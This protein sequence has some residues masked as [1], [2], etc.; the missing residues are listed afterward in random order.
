MSFFRLLH[1]ATF[2][3]AL[4]FSANAQTSI[5]DTKMDIST[6]G[7]TVKQII[8]EIEQDFGINF[9]YSDNLLPKT[10]FNEL[11]TR[12][13]LGS[14]LTSMLHP[15]DIDFKVIDNQIVLFESK[16]TD[17][18]CHVSGIMVDSRN[19]EIIINGAIYVSDLGVGAI[20]NNYGFFSIQMPEGVHRMKFHS[21]GYKMQD[22]VIEINGDCELAIRLDPVSYQ[23]REIT[24][25][26]A[27]DNF[28][29]SAMSNI[30]KLNIERLKEL[31]NV[32]GEHDALRNLDVMPGFQM[33]E[34]STSN[35][36]VRGGTGDQTTFLMDEANIYSASHLGG[37]SSIFNPDVVN[38]INIYKNEL[39]TSESG[40]LSSVIDVRLRD[41]DM[42]HWHASGTIGLLTARALIE[43]PLK[44]DKSSIL[45]AVRR[46]YAD[47]VFKPAWNRQNFKLN[48][49]FY[50]INFKFSYKFRSRDRLYFSLYSGADKIDH[51]M[52]LKRVSRVATLR[53]NHIWGDKIFLNYSII[54]S[55]NRTNL[56][57]FHYNGQFKWRSICWNTKEKL[58]ITHHVNQ[59]I[60]LKY[61][62]QSSFYSLEP[63]DL[64]SEDEVTPFKDA[65]IYAQPISNL[66]I[67]A[68]QT[69]KIGALVSLEAGFRYNAHIGPTDHTNKKD[70]T[71]LYPEWNFTINYK[72]SDR[73]LF[74]INTSSKTQPIHQLQVSSYSITINRWMPSNY[75]FMPEK[76]HNASIS[77]NY[78]ASAF[79]NVSANIYYRQMTNLIETMQEM[80]LVYEI[81]PEKFI[82]HSS[83]KVKGCELS[84]HTSFDNL[85]ITATYDYTD[86]KWH[87]QGL[88]NDKD[89]P[90]SFIRKHSFNIIGTYVIDNRIKISAGWQIASGVPYTA[91]V[92]KYVI[93]GKTVLQ[94]DENKINTKHLPNYN[95][96]DLSLDIDGK[97]NSTKR[98]KSYWSFAIYNVYARKNPLG[99]AY[100]TNN[101]HGGIKFRPGYYYFYQFVPS[102][103]YR[104]VF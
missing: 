39:P 97:E 30:T 31:P 40:S 23:L 15:N 35:I 11:E 34:L 96:L 84:A 75:R 99:V 27:A 103:S 1:T 46:T 20:S 71:I 87:T 63:F 4:A 70:T 13:T 91:A 58:D 9:S 74:K 5:L 62:F 52:Y 56:S 79:M 10:H 44:K 64:E 41:G 36:S 59:H 2:A 80:R 42:Q 68:D 57:N 19:S 7:K 93:D 50:D 60:D 69:Y 49:Y 51:S 88:N 101:E 21:L 92:G 25:S 22:T 48:F 55:Y 77:A 73:L 67:Y 29:E 81:N 8:T 3:L 78:K 65:R 45:L 76:S 47:K 17:K 54:G 83:A 26:D 100:F 98:W 33:S 6:S 53:W 24:V 28:M 89:Y 38:H 104:F 66:G 16:R 12:P 85:A 94:F 82:Y 95:R 14:L 72:A 61:G 37:F 32:L 18:Q 43:G 102:V 90:A 86:S